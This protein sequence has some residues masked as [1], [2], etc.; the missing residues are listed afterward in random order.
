MRRTMITPVLRYY[1]LAAN[2]TAFSSTRNGGYSKGCFAS[3]NVNEYCGD[4]A[5]SINKNRLALCSELG[6]SCDNLIMP[7][8][9]HG[10]TIRK[11][12]R[13]FLGLTYEERKAELENVDG[14]MTDVDNVC[15][16]VSTADCI[17]ILLYDTENRVC[18]AVHAGWRGTVKR[19]TEKAVGRMTAEYGT[20]PETLLACIGP[21]ISLEN[22]EVGDE[23]WQEFSDAGFAMD[24]IS[25]HYV[26]W[27]IDLWECNRR[28]LVNAGVN[29]HNIQVAGICTFSHADEFFSA[30]RLSI[31]S[32]RILTGI[33]MNK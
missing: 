22:F 9:N 21:G 14:V 18:C 7:H 13:L 4:E 28:Q 27:H 6:I 33:L 19:I 30:R 23:V 8:Q 29:P 20:R 11:V 31:H 32:G 2:V 26:K 1:H 16:A 10:T 17:P 24:E 15:V 12:D 5:D 3:F 25:R